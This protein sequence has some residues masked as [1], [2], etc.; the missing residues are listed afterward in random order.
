MDLPTAVAIDHKGRK[1]FSGAFG[2][3]CFDG[4]AW[5]GWGRS[6]LVAS[7]YVSD[8]A[9]DRDN[10]VW[11]VTSTGV[12]RIALD[13][14]E[15]AFD[16]EA[17][18]RAADIARAVRRKAAAEEQAAEAVHR[19]EERLR[20]LKSEG[21]RPTIVSYYSISDS[22][23][24]AASRDTLWV[25]LK[26]GVC[27]YDLASG[28]REFFPIRG[29]VRAIVRDS[30][31]VWWIG[32]YGGG[33]M[34]FDGTSMK[35]Y[36]RGTGLPSG[37]VQDIEIDAEGRVWVATAQGAACF[38]GKEW[39]T[40]KIDGYKDVL[41]IR[42]DPKGALWFLTYRGVLRFAKGE[43]KTYPIET[44]VGAHPESRL[45]PPLEVDAKGRVWV[46]AHW[47]SSDARKSRRPSRRS[48]GRAAPVARGSRNVQS[49]FVFNGVRWSRHTGKTSPFDVPVRAGTSAPRLYRRPGMLKANS[50]ARKVA[51]ELGRT[52]TIADGEIRCDDGKRQRTYALGK[53]LIGSYVSRIAVG[54]DGRKW[55]LTRKGLCWF[56]NGKWGTPSGASLN[57]GMGAVYLAV[58]G[59][60]RVWTTKGSFNGVQCFDGRKWTHRK[61]KGNTGY[62]IKTL[63]LDNS[64]AVWLATSSDT[65]FRLDGRSWQTYTSSNGLAKGYIRDIKPDPRRGV[66]VLVLGSTKVDG[67]YQWR[68]RVCRFD[69]KTWR[70]YS[71]PEGVPAGDLRRITVNASGHVLAWGSGVL[72]YYDGQ[73]WRALGEKDGIRN[74]YVSCVYADPDGKFWLGTQRGVICFD[75]KGAKEYQHGTFL[76]DVKAMVM[77]RRQRLWL[78]RAG[79]LMSFDGKDWQRWT[80]DDLLADNFVNCLALDKDGSIWVGTR[81]GVSHIVFGPSKQPV[82][83]S[84][85]AAGP[86]AEPAE[87]KPTTSV[88]RTVLRVLAVGANLER[89]GL[90]DAARKTYEKAVRKYPNA[91]EIGKVKERLAALKARVKTPK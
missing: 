24:M 85:G 14:D 42:G 15:K 20:D 44:V 59:R 2:T 13:E 11:V 88:D 38:D 58:D 16:R 70:V 87:R 62:A 82:V 32:A 41:T 48:R 84:A 76:S 46:K 72:G 86:A 91:P 67:K 22:T 6:D 52:W 36:A 57:F 83:L 12:S 3:A 19:G 10:S 73:S 51:D 28:R 21:E 8:L 69:G 74:T 35:H 71:Q 89:N 34:R 75:G 78:G 40:H 64:G 27:R 45:N 37:G 66:W 77:D 54:P 4:K 33:V 43:W 49:A 7:G 29:D 90:I 61:P 47:K 60:G 80:R 1:W 50:W 31:G 26:G 18:K 53:G 30:K 25:G 17:A 55:F 79:D 68:G 5:R 9:V 63:E 23:C 56:D 65:V 39:K 81:T